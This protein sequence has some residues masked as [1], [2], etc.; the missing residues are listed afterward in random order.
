MPDFGNQNQFEFSVIY[1]AAEIARYP[2]ERV[3]N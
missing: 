1:E 3:M 2:L